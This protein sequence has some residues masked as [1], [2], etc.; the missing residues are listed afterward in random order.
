MLDCLKI[1]LRGEE[2]WLSSRRSLWWP[3]HKTLVV[4]DLHLGKGISFSR[5]SNLLP[6][7]DTSDTLTRLRELVFM[8]CKN[9]NDK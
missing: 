6:P 9:L 2:V 8:I 1:K 7:Y 3:F 5:N 4:S